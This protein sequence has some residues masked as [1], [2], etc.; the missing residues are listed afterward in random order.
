MKIW[1][2]SSFIK[3]IKSG[4]F[5]NSI[6]FWS[7]CLCIV[8]IINFSF[9]FG[10]SFSKTEIIWLIEFII[11]KSFSVNLI[12]NN[13]YLSCSINSCNFWI[14]LSFILNESLIIFRTFCELNVPY[15]FS[16]CLSPSKI[17]S[18]TLLKVY[19]TFLFEGSFL[20]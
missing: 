12:I 10:F 20:K 16:I 13:L 14:T 2:Y 4:S 3:G 7:L 15:S 1:L 6:P 9:N 8:N 19:I 17:F 11:N 18:V 5:F